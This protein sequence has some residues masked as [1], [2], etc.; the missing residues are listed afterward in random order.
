MQKPMTLVSREL[1]ERSGYYIVRMKMG[2]DEVADALGFLTYE[3][4]WSVEKQEWQ[5]GAGDDN[6]VNFEVTAWREITDGDDDDDD[7]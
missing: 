3:R 4:W 2:T 5:E 6:P 7:I 1:P